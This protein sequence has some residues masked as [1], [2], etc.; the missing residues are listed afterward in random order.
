VIDAHLVPASASSTSQSIMIVRS[1]RRLR[2][3]T[4][5]SERPI[6]RWISCVRPLGRPL[7]T[8]RAERSVVARGSIEYSAVTQP[9]PEPRI[10][11]GASSSTEAATS[12]FVRPCEKSTEPSAQSW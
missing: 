7:V 10:H 6:S 12:T 9:L 8:S 2:S 5:R 11:R 3:V 1:P 4:A